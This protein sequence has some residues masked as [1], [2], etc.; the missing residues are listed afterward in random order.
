MI[1]V[2]VGVLVGGGVG[3]DVGVRV[4]VGVDVDVDVDVGVGVGV[5]VEVKVGVGLG[6]DVAVA[7]GVAVRVGVAVGV[8]VAVAVGVGGEGATF[9]AWGFSRKPNTNTA[10]NPISIMAARKP[11]GTNVGIE[12]R[13]LCSGLVRGAPHMRHSL[14]LRATRVPQAGQYLLSSVMLACFFP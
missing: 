9:A 14:A 1:G 7:V 5:E 3:V 4:G 10:A 6:V 11:A 2:G 12:I 13:L 8:A